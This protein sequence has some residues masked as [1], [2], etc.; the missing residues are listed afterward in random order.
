MGYYKNVTQDDVRLHAAKLW[1]V[2]S[3][4]PVKAGK[5]G[6]KNISEVIL[7]GKSGA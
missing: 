7:S 4:T 1:A 3:K 6:T 2:R 5:N